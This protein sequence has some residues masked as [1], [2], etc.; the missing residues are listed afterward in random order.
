MTRSLRCFLIAVTISVVILF[1]VLA[2]NRFN[3]E[4]SQQKATVKFSVINASPEKYYKDNNLNK[5]D[6]K[7]YENYAHR[8][9]YKWKS[10][11]KYVYNVVKDVKWHA[12][13]EYLLSHETEGVDAG[14]NKLVFSNQPPDPNF[15]NIEKR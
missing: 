14:K 10:E 6:S 2:V 7:L 11:F 8:G 5:L 9:G 3:D 1:V 4:K 12:W 13:D 15:F